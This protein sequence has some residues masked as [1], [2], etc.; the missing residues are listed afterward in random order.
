LH[1]VN[2]VVCEV[3]DTSVLNALSTMQVTLPTLMFGDAATAK[4]A[5]N[6]HAS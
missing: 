2:R 4:I 5:I 1:E 6:H 3:V